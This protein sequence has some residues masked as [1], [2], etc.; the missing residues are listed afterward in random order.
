MTYEVLAYPLKGA[1]TASQG[2][3]PT[4]FTGEPPGFWY[5]D[6]TLDYYNATDPTF[7]SLTSQRLDHV[8]S[9]IDWP[10]PAGTAIYAPADGVV[11]FAGWDDTGY[12][13]CLKIHH[14]TVTTLYGHTS[15][16]LVNMGQ[17]VKAGQPVARVGSTGN[18]TGS[19]LHF[20]V[21]RDSDGHYDD[22]M[23]YLSATPVKPPIPPKPANAVHWQKFSGTTMAGT[24]RLYA[25]PDARF[26]VLG[27]I[28][29]GV[30]LTFSAWMWGQPRMDF[31][32]HAFD[33]RWYFVSSEQANGTGWVQSARVQGNASGSAP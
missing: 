11:T 1:L 21:L 10:Q 12:G 5:S 32:T 15:E 26:P 23:R 18:S 2:Y 13:N 29:P 17:S 8:H 7:P 22:P 24:T 31:S 30:T 33:R 19:H 9:G 20:S 16:F 28:N 27:E 14:V 6:R 4:D 3:G 25:G